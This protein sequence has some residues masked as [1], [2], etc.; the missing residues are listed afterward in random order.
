MD[1]VS[2]LSTNVHFHPSKWVCD[3][4]RAFSELVYRCH[5]RSDTWRHLK[6][7]TRSWQGDDS[8]IWVTPDMLVMFWFATW[9]VT[10]GDTWSRGLGHDREVTQPTGTPRHCNRGHHEIANTNSNLVHF[11]LITK[12][13]KMYF[14]WHYSIAD[15]KSILGLNLFRIH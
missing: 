3:R 1:M 15:L 4:L 11:L 6:Q 9:G 5:M 7:G 10:H 12:K 14:C 8:A 13:L 2:S